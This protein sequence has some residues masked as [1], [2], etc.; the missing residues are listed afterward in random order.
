VGGSLDEGVVRLTRFLMKE[1][2]C[3]ET[4]CHDYGDILIFE[5]LPNLLSSPA[6]E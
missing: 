6:Q 5:D 3:G 2:S 4:Y 1:P